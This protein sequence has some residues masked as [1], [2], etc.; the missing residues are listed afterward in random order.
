MRS[1]AMIRSGRDLL[2]VLLGCAA[3]VG[4][5]DG[6]LAAP[7][8]DLRVAPARLE[9]PR[10]ASPGAGPALQLD[11]ADL[12]RGVFRLPLALEAPSA[13]G[14]LLASVFPY[15]SRENGIS[16][17]GMGWNAELAI[18]RIAPDTYVSPWGPLEAGDDGA[19]YPAGLR[20]LVR[21]KPTADGG[22]E[23]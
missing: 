12:A 17:W 2:A 7:L 1:P 23:A 22:W 14:P 16:E 9:P 15:Y 13:R 20:S 18:R 5:M 3:T 6:A 19:Y 21:V 4:A 8:D 11:P 10:P